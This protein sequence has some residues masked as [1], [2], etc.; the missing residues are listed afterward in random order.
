[1]ALDGV[2]VRAGLDEDAVF[3]ED[4]GGAQHVLALVHRVGDVVEAAALAG[5]IFGVGDIV[6]LVVD[7]EPAAAQAAVVELD[8]LRHPAAERLRHEVADDRYVGGQQVEVVDAAHGDAASVIALGKV[9]EGRAL[10][11]RR[12]VDLRVVIELEDV[13]VGIVEAIGAA[14]TGIA[15]VPADAAAHA[16]Y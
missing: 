14:V 9:L 4:V 13:A 1:G 3:E 7:R 2:L 16:F 11:R 12:L 6:G 8:L 10:L 15:F 5:M